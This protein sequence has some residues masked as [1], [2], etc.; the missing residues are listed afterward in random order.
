M[1]RATA[2]AAVTAWIS[3][4]NVA[5]LNTVYASWPKLGLE[6]MF[7]STTPGVTTGAVAI[8]GILSSSEERIAIGGATSGWKRVRH[9]VDLDV[10][11]RSVG[12]DGVAAQQAF[13]TTL[14]ALNARLRADRTL[15]DATV[16]QALEGGFTVRQDAPML[17]AEVVVIH[18]DVQF[19]LDE[20][21]QA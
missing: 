19:L 13:D 17:N 12:T 1:S 14:D 11:F 5:G 9:T 7:A 2:R 18:A 6:Q 10:W 3:P 16:W 21:T 8:V 20:M 4:P 15:G